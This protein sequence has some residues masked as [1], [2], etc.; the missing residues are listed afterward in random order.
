MAKYSTPEEDTLTKRIIR[1]R[2]DID[3][4]SS[5]LNLANSSVRGGRVRFVT[6]GSARFEED[7]VLEILDNAI[8]R[9][10][11]DGQISII[12]GGV[13]ESGEGGVVRSVS[14]EQEMALFE[15]RLV[16]ANVDPDSEENS[17]HM[18]AHSP[19]VISIDPS[20]EIFGPG[21]SVLSPWKE[22]N[23]RANY[24]LLEGGSTSRGGLIFLKSGGEIELNSIANRIIVSHSTTSSSAN[25]N[26]TTRGQIRRSTSASR[27]K[28]DV[29]NLVIDPDAVLSLEAKTWRDR[30]EVA[31]NPNSDNWYIGYMA[32]ELESL[33]LDVFVDYNEHGDPENIEYDRMSVALLSVIKRQQ[34]QIDHL[35]ERLGFSQP[36]GVQSEPT[37]KPK[38]QEPSRVDEDHQP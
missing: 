29:E 38:R 18:I 25:C 21:V 8:L 22:G 35:Y 27:Y 2:K 31:E 15:G 9:V 7:S 4:A 28:Q 26:I 10:G 20:I 33:G 32:E 23:G 13:L 6:G 19:G 11:E 37:V 3:K 16:Y 17:G 5:S 14:N 36:E 12:E 30:N 34:S 1:I 24:L